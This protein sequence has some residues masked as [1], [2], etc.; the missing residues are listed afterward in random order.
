MKLTNIPHPTSDIDLDSLRFRTIPLTF[1]FSTT[2]IWLSF[3]TLKQY[4]ESQ[5]RPE[6]GDSDAPS[7]R[8]AARTSLPLR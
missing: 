3:S 6:N 1:R 2:I 7:L 4:I 5:D 8:D